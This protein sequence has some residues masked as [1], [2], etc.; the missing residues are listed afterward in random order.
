VPG[1]HAT[2]VGTIPEL[3]D[4]FL[5]PTFTEPYASDL[6][7]RLRVPAGGRLLELACGTGRLTRQLAAALPAS[8]SIDATDLN[9][10]MVNVARARVSAANVRWGTA[11]ATALPFGDAEFD[12]VVCQFGVMFFP[13]KVAA[14]RQV[15]RVLKAGGSYW[16]STWSSLDEN[17]VS[18]VAREVGVRFLGTDTPVFVNIPFGYHDRERIVADLRAGG[19]ATIEVDVVDL[20]AQAASAQ[21]VAMGL[22]QGSPMVEQIRHYGRATVDEVTAAV[23]EALAREFGAAPLRGPMRALAVH[24]R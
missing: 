8:V 14:A 3:Y 21:E 1:S 6:V 17:P 16:F 20:E 10:P 5:A 9:E 4:R 7:S 2:F 24:A 15:R 12:A 13:D 22:V 19:F 23:A 18:R 11:D